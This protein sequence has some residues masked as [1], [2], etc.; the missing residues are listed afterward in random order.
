MARRVGVEVVQLWMQAGKLRPVP[1]SS[2]VGVDLGFSEHAR[3]NCGFD[4][5]VLG[6]KLLLGEVG[7]A[8]APLAAPSRDLGL[9]ARQRRRETQ[10]DVNLRSAADGHTVADADRAIDGGAGIDEVI[11]QARLHRA[12]DDEGSALYQHHSLT[13][14]P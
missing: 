7:L 13:A 8:D 2:I 12:G 4:P 10:V 14:A 3:A 11:Y 5:L 9:N 6:R 1:E